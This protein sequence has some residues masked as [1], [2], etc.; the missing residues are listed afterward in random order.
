LNLDSLSERLENLP[1]IVKVIINILLD[2]ITFLTGYVVLRYGCGFNV[3]LSCIGGI[4]YL[5]F[6]WWIV[7]MN[8]REK[9][10]QEGN[11]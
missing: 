4:N 3:N 10:I 7:L 8:R 1:K 9:Q 11:I 2:F 5:L 6:S